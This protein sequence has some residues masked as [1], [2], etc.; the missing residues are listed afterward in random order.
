[1]TALTMTHAD[2]VIKEAFD[3]PEWYLTKTAY[4]IRVRIETIL[5]FTRDLKP[6]NILD[7]GCGDGSLSR[8][9]LTSTN[10]LTL[11]DR[12][13]RM[14]EIAQ[15]GLPAGSAE[16]VTVLN[17]DFIGFEVPN[18]TFDLII[19][20]GIMAYIEDR[21]AFLEK[22]A[23][24]LKPNGTVIMECT[25]GKHFITHL[26]RGYKALR[27]KLAGGEF[28]TVTKGSAELLNL[29]SEH[30]FQ[31]DGKFRYSLPLPGMR[32]LLSQGISYRGIRML[33]G[34]PTRNR[35]PWLG[36]ECLFRLRRKA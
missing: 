5:E 36:N 9:L 1:M 16:R 25:D 33:Y 21:R 3:R 18:Q 2:A 20:V 17:D 14:L 15:V 4:N 28:P 6:Q 7:I 32:K 11:V 31:V 19:C 8:S 27:T 22:V 34:S 29:V 26:I 24:A 23:A 12:S 35:V 10:R 30:G 13:R